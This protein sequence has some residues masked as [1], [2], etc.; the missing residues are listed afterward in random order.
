MNHHR[1]NQISKNFLSNIYGVWYRFLHQNLSCNV[2]SFSE[3]VK[4]TQSRL[5]WNASLSVVGLLL[6]APVQRTGCLDWLYYQTKVSKEN[7]FHCLLN[8]GLPSKK[9]SFSKPKFFCRFAQER[10]LLTAEYFDAIEWFDE[11]R[12][13]PDTELAELPPFLR[14]NSPPSTPFFFAFG[15][16]KCEALYYVTKLSSK[17]S[18]MSPNM[19]ALGDTIPE[20]S[21]FPS[22]W[23]EV[24]PTLRTKPPRAPT[25][26]KSTPESRSKNVR[27]IQPG[28]FAL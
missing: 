2:I 16:S 8:A 9:M 13:T 23:L 22:C 20:S 1:M 5:V 14:L 10:P 21:P 7:S 12:E 26:P 28:M 27:W 18:S 17:M 6:S 15:V 19:K 3:L 4:R 11:T 25:W 24:G